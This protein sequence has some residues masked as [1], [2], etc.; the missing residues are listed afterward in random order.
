MSDYVGC[1][2][3]DGNTGSFGSIR[4]NI[5]VIN[6][7]KNIYTAK[8]FIAKSRKYCSCFKDVA[9]KD[10]KKLKSLFDISMEV[11]MKNI[12]LVDFETIPEAII[13]EIFLPWIYKFGLLQNSDCIDCWETLNRIIC[14][15]HHNT[16][17][18][19]VILGLG[20][21]ILFLAKP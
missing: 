3:R 10:L 17:L 13:E 5:A 11:I 19:K 4:A 6:R 20:R 9:N 15:P 18:G 8:P 1:F 2:I 7:S 21:K 12:H 14:L 16:K